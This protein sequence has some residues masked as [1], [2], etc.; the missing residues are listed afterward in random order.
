MGSDW[1]SA[2]RPKRQRARRGDRGADFA[3]RVLVEHDVDRAGSQAR[4]GSAS[5]SSW[6]MTRTLP[7]RPDLLERRAAARH[8]RRRDCR[9][10]RGRDAPRAARSAAVSV[11]A[12]SSS[13]RAGRSSSMPGNS[14]AQQRRKAF[15]PLAVVAQAERAGDQADLARPA[16]K[17]PSSDAAV[18]P[19]G[20]VVDADEV[21]A[22][23]ARQVGDQR[24]DRDAA[25]ASPRRPPC[26]PPS[27]SVATITAQSQVLADRARRARE[28]APR[29][30]APVRAASRWCMRSVAAGRARAGRRPPRG[31]TMNSLRPSGMR[32]A[33][34]RSRARASSEAERSR[35]KSSARIASSTFSAVAGRTPGRAVEHAVDG[36]E[37]NAGL[38]RHVVHGR[39][40]RPRP[41]SSS[42]CVPAATLGGLP[43]R[44]STFS[45]S[46][47]AC[48]GL[49][50]RQS[51]LSRPPREC[52]G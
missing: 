29:H 5:V 8:C 31:L 7:A 11:A 18:R 35:R 36:R 45:A 25:A 47:L 19:G 1:T 10:R 23:R 28:P 37:R 50:A 3:V 26:A 27:S 43:Q 41:T 22:R 49:R 38:A 32:K 9:A 52:G 15:E 51:R 24:H 39:P 46:F 21:P 16:Q 12:L 48:G 17:R 6:A 40:R 13:P 33:T 4:R 20:H 44:A 34:R 14:R 2:S 30:R 42:S